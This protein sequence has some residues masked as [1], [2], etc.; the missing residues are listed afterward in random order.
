M[1]AFPCIPPL[2]T[3]PGLCHAV[4]IREQLVKLLKRFKVPLTS[5][6]G[7]TYNVHMSFFKSHCPFFFPSKVTQSQYSNV[8]CLDSS[9]MQLGYTTLVHIALYEATILYTYTH[10]PFSTQ[11]GLLNGALPCTLSLNNHAVHAFVMKF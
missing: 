2:S 9:R 7:I 10:P 6:G 1:S 4:S 3:S 11:R 5:C 8:S